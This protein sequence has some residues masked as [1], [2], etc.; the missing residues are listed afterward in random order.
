LRNAFRNVSWGT[1]ST[2]CGS[3]SIPNATRRS[4][5]SWR[6]SRSSRR[7]LG[8]VAAE[9]GLRPRGSRVRARGA[10]GLLPRLPRATVEVELREEDFVTGPELTELHG[11][12]LAR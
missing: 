3:P 6:A 1:S 10:G 9:A 4:I 5:P 2:R 12:I 8:D 7:R 11:G